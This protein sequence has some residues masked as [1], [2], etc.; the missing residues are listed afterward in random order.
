MNV[1]C[2]I[3]A[4]VARMNTATKEP[5]PPEDLP[6]Q[7]RDG[8]PDEYGQFKWSIKKAD[9]R[10]WLSDLMYKLPRKARGTGRLGGRS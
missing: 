9:C 5:L 10:Q 8:E 2:V 6:E 3:D 1:D 4:F 7:L